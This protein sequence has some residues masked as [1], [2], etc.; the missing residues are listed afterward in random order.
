MNNYKNIKI[1]FFYYILIFTLLQKYF[2]L[3]V[4]KITNITI[5]TTYIFYKFIY[6]YI[7]IEFKLIFKKKIN[8]LNKKNF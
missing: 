7:I 8:L 1:N 2:L 6:F 4:S 5:F 3:L